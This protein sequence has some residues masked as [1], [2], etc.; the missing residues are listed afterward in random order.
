MSVRTGCHFRTDLH[1]ADEVANVDN[2][3][4]LDYLTSEVALEDPET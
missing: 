3:I 1:F 2:V 4:L